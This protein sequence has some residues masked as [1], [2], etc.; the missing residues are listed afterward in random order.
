[1]RINVIYLKDAKDLQELKKLY[2]TYAKRL[3]PD[4]TK[5]NGEAMK[6][7]NNEYDYLKTILHNAVN[8]E[9]KKAY[10]DNNASMDSFR[11]IIN[12]LLKYNR[13]VIEIVGSWLW[14]SG[15][16]TFAIKDSVLYEKFNFQYS[17][18][19][20]KF[21]WY[22]GISEDK[23]IKYRGGYLK[24]AINKYGYTKLESELKPE[25]N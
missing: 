13:I 3:H 2:Y 15:S 6:Q 5:D 10:T 1:M 18:H 19:N 25:L 14:V 20:K 24:E 11:D 22:D 23:K 7:L 9:T 12:E 21:Y 4:V 8:E 17:K 16:G